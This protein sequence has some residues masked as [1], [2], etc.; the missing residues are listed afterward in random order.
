MRATSFPHKYYKSKMCSN[1]SALKR[2]FVG[3]SSTNM[4]GLSTFHIWKTL[5]KISSDLFKSQPLI[6][7]I[8]FEMAK[9]IFTFAI[10]IAISQ[11]EVNIWHFDTMFTQPKKHILFCL[12]LKCLHRTVWG[13][14]N[15]FAQDSGTSHMYVCLD[16]RSCILKIL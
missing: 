6:S 7:N 2:L 1:C 12:T 4:I 13:E 8:Y 11:L 10:N 3:R 14:Y 5:R 15:A 16:E 9:I